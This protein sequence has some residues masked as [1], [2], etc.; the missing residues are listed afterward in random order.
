MDCE[1]QRSEPTLWCALHE[2]PLRSAG[3]GKQTDA[4]AVL[5]VDAWVVKGAATP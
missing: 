1:F 5:D 2:E 3:P 4:L